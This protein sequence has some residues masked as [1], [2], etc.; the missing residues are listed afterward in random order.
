MASCA[1]EL[2]RAVVRPAGAASRRRWR[3]SALR[4]ARPQ[5]V[6][7]RLARG[8][9]P[10]PDLRPGD[11]LAVSTWVWLAPGAPAG[12]RRALIASWGPGA[13]T[14]GRSCSIAEGRPGF[15]V[16]AGGELVRV[17]ADG[18]RRA[19]PGGGSRACSTRAPA[20]I[21][22]SRRPRRRRRDDGERPRIAAPG[23]A[24]GPLVIGAERRGPDAEAEA[25][26]TASSTAPRSAVGQR[27]R[28]VG[29]W[30]LGHGRAA[31]G[32]RP[33]AAWAS[34]DRC[35]NGP[36]RAVTGPAGAAT[37]TTGA[38]AASSTRRCTSTPTPSTISAGSRPWSS[39]SAE[40]ARAASTRRARGRRA[41]GRGP[42][43]RAPRRRRRRRADA[44]C[45]CRRFTYLAY[46]CERD[47]PGVDR[48]EQA[49]DRWVARNGLRSLYDRY[50]DGCGV[51]EASLLRPLTQLRP[52]YRCPQHGG[53]HGLAQDLILLGLLG[54]TG[55]TS[56]CS[57]ITTSTPR[58]PRRSPAIA[59]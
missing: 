42:L 4:R 35:V 21:S 23:P 50:D 39:R 52:G 8:G 22:I 25:T 12:R 38:G 29:A 31:R 20:T 48:S 28:R 3:S 19:I 11:G 18:P 41:R 57:P 53:P 9:R 51:Y 45:C 32:A 34:T 14:A 49:E 55:S 24:P 16:A 46:S 44:P 2:E 5:P 15:E 59:P 1:G 43:R 36:L 47:A 13:T 54:A 58:A 10:R 27:E 37:S 26:S 6:R 7:H 33:R 56:T 40:P 30:G 17:V